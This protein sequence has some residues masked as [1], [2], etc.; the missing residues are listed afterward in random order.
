M[1]HFA[2]VLNSLFVFS[3]MGWLPIGN[4][5]TFSVKLLTATA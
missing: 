5:G 2:N 3:A 1:Y 4:V